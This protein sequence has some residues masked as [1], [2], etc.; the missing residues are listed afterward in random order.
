MIRNGTSF[1][2]QV[3][4]YGSNWANELSGLPG[5]LRS[6]KGSNLIDEIDADNL[7]VNL[8]SFA[9]VAGF[10]LTAIPDWFKYTDIAHRGASVSVDAIN[11]IAGISVASAAVGGVALLGL[12]GAPEVMVAGGV[13]ILAGWATDHVLTTPINTLIPQTT[14]VVGDVTGNS[15]LPGL[16]GAGYILGGLGEKGGKIITGLIDPNVSQFSIKD[17][18]IEGLSSV[19]NTAGNGLGSADSECKPIYPTIC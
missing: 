17:M 15:L 14:M 4:I 19:I 6:I 11:S 9:A 13:V 3:V 7:G 1:P 10:A 16:P 2:D 18:E 12:V 5:T 8:P